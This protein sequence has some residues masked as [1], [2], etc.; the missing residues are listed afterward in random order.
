MRLRARSEPDA[1]QQVSP[2]FW[3]RAEKEPEVSPD[4]KFG[5][6]PGEPEQHGPGVAPELPGGRRTTA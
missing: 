4:R 6:F 3:R 2:G 5:V 1:P